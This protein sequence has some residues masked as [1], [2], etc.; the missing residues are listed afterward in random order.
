MLRR[1]LPF[2][3][4]AMMLAFAANTADAAWG[5]SG[6]GGWNSWGRYW[7]YGY[8]DGY[9][10]KPRYAPGAVDPYPTYEPGMW[11]EAQQPAP[12]MRGRWLSPAPVQSPTVPNVPGASSRTAPRWSPRGMMGRNGQSQGPEVGVP[13]VEGPGPTIAQPQPEMDGPELQGPT[14]A[15]APADPTYPDPSARRPNTSGGVSRQVPGPSYQYPTP[16]SR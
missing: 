14:E 12:M 5:L 13:Q 15:T 6:W 4:V 16:A 7:G 10:A 1:L 11:H 9:H 3:S 8:S 2:L